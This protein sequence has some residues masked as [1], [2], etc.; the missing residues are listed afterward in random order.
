MQSLSITVAFRITGTSDQISL[1]VRGMTEAMEKSGA[2]IIPVQNEAPSPAERPYRKGNQLSS[3]KKRS[4][5]S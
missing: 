3:Q 4:L 5:R 2:E 1:A